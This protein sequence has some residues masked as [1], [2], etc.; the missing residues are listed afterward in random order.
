MIP[1]ALTI[2]GSDS[3]GGA[4]IQADLK[5]FAALGVYGASAITAITA[6][7]TTGVRAV[8]AVPP[9]IVAAQIDAVREDLAINAIK[10]GMVFSAAIVA[11][12]ADSLE[13]H[14][15]VAVVVDPVMI[16][17]SG[18]RLI[19]AT[20]SEVLVKRLFP[21][22]ACVTPNLAEAAALTGQCMASSEAEMARQGKAIL[23]LGA[24]AVL[25]KG[26]HAT[27]ENSVDLLITATDTHRYTAQRITSRNL[28]GTGCTLA[29]AIAA[30]LAKGASLI[31][32]IESAKSYLTRA[33]A[34]GANQRIGHGHGPVHHF[35]AFDLS[36]GKL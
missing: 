2:A 30:E 23:E 24:H 8:H 28:H 10:I 5:T 27:G 29:S 31:A 13:R 14:R 16:A 20:A 32:A 17:T 11:A 3:S 36:G 15:R 35:H 9:D 7:N 6:Q 18:D 1:M 33:I 4:G 22:S 21:I 25:M 19:D 26:G 34:A 12:I